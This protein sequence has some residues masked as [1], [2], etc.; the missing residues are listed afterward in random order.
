MSE[1]ATDNVLAENNMAL[2]DL[3]T[4][5]VAAYV[6]HQHIPTTEVPGLITSVFQTLQGLAS[7]TAVVS[8]AVEDTVELKDKAEIKKS[9]KKDALISFIDGKSYKTLKRHLSRHGLT[10]EQ[11][12]TKFGLPPDYPMVSAD[13]SEQR[14]NLA[15]SMGLGRGAQQEAA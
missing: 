8:G 14:S 11:Y 10:P 1:A 7:G 5:I 6:G 13:Y 12:K 15:K 2:I 3:S 9:I 4:G